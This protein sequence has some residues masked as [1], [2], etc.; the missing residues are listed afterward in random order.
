MCPAFKVGRYVPEP[1]IRISEALG[2]KV[3]LLARGTKRIVSFNKL[4]KAKGGTDYLLGEG[5]TVVGG[6]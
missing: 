3:C 4:K 2:G 6:T 5:G 1:P